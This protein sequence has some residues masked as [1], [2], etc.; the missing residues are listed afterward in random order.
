MFWFTFLHMHAHSDTRTC[1]HKVIHPSI[2]TLRVR[3]AAF[4]NE[5]S[6][7]FVVITGSVCPCVFVSLHCTMWSC[8][9]ASSTVI[10]C[11]IDS[12]AVLQST[13]KYRSVHIS[14]HVSAIH[15]WNRSILPMSSRCSHFSE[16]WRCWSICVAD[17]HIIRWASAACTAMV[18][19]LKL[20][21]NKAWSGD[22]WIYWLRQTEID[23]YETDIAPQCGT[24]CG[25]FIIDI[26]DIHYWAANCQI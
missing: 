2:H 22:Y 16:S 9:A 19:H 24:R 1:A 13:A 23:R 12:L 11:C 26:A 14:M 18:K 8:S 7:M 25:T 4:A 3:H 21:V 17:K 6:R 20:H 10:W 15:M 5:A